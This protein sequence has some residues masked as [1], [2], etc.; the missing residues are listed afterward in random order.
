MQNMQLLNFKSG[1]IISIVLI[2]VLAFFVFAQFIEHDEAGKA[3]CISEDGYCRDV[4]VRAG[5]PACG[6]ARTKYTF[7]SNEKTCIMI[8]ECC[9][10]INCNEGKC[11][12]RG[13]EQPDAKQRYICAALCQEIGECNCENGLDS[14]TGDWMWIPPPE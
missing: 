12:I 4:L 6:A 9:T 2:L 7:L 10:D 13:K 14:C 1:F 5:E 8:E 3:C 11:I